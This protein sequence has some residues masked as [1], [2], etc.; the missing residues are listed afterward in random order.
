M[1]DNEMSL[2]ELT[3]LFEIL[4]PLLYITMQ[5]TALHSCFSSQQSNEDICRS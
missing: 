3:K 2:V 5:S 1:V 4:T